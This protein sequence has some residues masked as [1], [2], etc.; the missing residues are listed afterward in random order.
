MLPAVSSYILY[1]VESN[2]DSGKNIGDLISS[3]GYCRKTVETCFFKE[4]GLS[5]GVYLF[6]RKMSRASVLLRLTS[7][8]VTEIAEILNYSSSQNFTRAFRRFTG[9]TPSE[10]RKNKVWDVSVLQNS[11]LHNL[12]IGNIYEYNLP[13][14]FLTGK[15]Y[16]IQESFFYKPEHESFNGLQKLMQKIFFTGGNDI[17][18]SVKIINTPELSKG[19][20]GIVNVKVIVGKLSTEKQSGDFKIPGGDFCYCHFVGSW[21]DYYIFSFTFFI[22]LLADGKYT[23]TGGYHYIDFHHINSMDDDIIS[24]NLFI[25]VNKS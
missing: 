10:Y 21:R 22:K 20:S 7:L 3:T 23:Y 24:C 5:L 25:P 8:T 4:Y 16:H 11:F 14:R 9:K 17:S 2:L 1:W 15:T 19:R 13:E 12:T 6:R 18:V